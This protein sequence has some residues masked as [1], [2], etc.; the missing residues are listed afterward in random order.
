MKQMKRIAS[1]LLVTALLLTLSV[2]AFAAGTTGSITIKGTTDVPVTGKT[3]AAYKILDLTLTADGKGYAYTVPAALEAFYKQHFNITEDELAKDTIHVIVQNRLSALT[4]NSDA[5]F[6]FATA[7]LAAAKTAQITPVKS[8]ISGTDAVIANLP[9]GYYV[10]EDEGTA[11]PI[12]ALVLDTSVPEVNINIKADKPSHKKEIVGGTSADA[13]DVNVGDTVNFK[14]TVDAPD[15]IGY[16]ADD[17]YTFIVSDTMSSGLTF[18]GSVEVTVGNTKVEASEKT[19]TLNANPGNGKTFTVTFASDYIKDLEKDTVIEI[20]YSATL[21]QN[22][23][24]TNVE[25]NKSNLTYSNNPN[26]EDAT[27]TTPDDIVYVYDFDVVIDKF[28]ANS[29]Q[30]TKLANAKFKLYKMVGD[31]KNYYVVNAETGVVTW[32]TDEAQATEVT[33]NADGYAAFKG[34]DVG[35]YYLTETAAPDGYNKLRDDITVTITA[36]YDENDG[37]METTNTTKVS[38]QYTLEVDVENNTGAELPETGGMGT[39]IFYTVGAI[40]VLAA[41]VLLVTKRRMNVAE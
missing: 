40:L 20:T 19:W 10:V 39:T 34:L 24:T 32:T 28:A 18:G 2:G 13:T 17:T 9:L 6:T 7:A 27:E 29:E 8:T 26:A 3:F 11:T 12:S 41:V 30:A 38:N 15:T 36:T 14:I 25:T 33:T 31:V 21:N 37:T 23:L 4:D 22:A 35:T 5:L 16:K 1:L